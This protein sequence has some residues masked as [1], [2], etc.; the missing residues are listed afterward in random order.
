MT[1]K[2]N[3]YDPDICVR[4]HPSYWY[5][6]S[7]E[8]TINRRTILKLVNFVTTTPGSPI[9][10]KIVIPVIAVYGVALG[11]YIFLNSGSVCALYVLILIKATKQHSNGTLDC[12]EQLEMMG[13]FAIV[14][15]S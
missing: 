3:Y 13:N 8:W 7:F 12:T 9:Y 14:N 15:I 11:F 5:H 6:E 2:T 10:D 4:Y 1:S